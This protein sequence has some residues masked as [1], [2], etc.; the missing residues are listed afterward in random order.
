MPSYKTT[1][2]GAILVIAFTPAAFAEATATAA[3]ADCGSDFA[4][5]DADGNGYVSE[6]EAPRAYARS[7][8]DGVKVA[9]T[10]LSKDD[11]AALCSAP[12]WAANTPRQAPPSKVPT[13]SPKVRRAT[14]RWHGT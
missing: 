8:V 5:L 1:L 12:N 7:R 2:I 6:S 9:D 11:Y 10:G 4:A 13:V 14:G 3:P